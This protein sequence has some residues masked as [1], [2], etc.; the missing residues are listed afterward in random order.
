MLVTQVGDSAATTVK[1]SE[2]GNPRVVTS[3]FVVCN[4]E[5]FVVAWSPK[6]YATNPV[7]APGTNELCFYP[8]ATSIVDGAVQAL[9]PSHCT[10]APIPGCEALYSPPKDMGNG[11]VR[12]TAGTRLTF[13]GTGD[14][15]L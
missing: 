3:E 10:A 1:T 6:P 9:W 11:T 5:G 12:V 7:E 8:F 15:V 13:T 4:G 14:P 2:L